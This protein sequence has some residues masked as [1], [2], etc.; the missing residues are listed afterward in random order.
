MGSGFLLSCQVVS[1]C[2]IP[3]TDGRLRK[4]AVF[5]IVLL[6]KRTMLS[7]DFEDLERLKYPYKG[8]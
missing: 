8:A 6:A 3:E 7:I 5:A 4:L 1:Q 2:K